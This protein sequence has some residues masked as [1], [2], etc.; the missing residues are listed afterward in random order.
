MDKLAALEMTIREEFPNFEV[1]RKSD[2]RLMSVIHTLLMCISF[3]QM[4]TFMVDFV[5][6]LGTTVYVPTKW[7]TWPVPSK[8][9]VLRHERVHMRQAKKYGR[10]LYSFLYLFVPLPIGL[11]YYRMLFEK[12]AYTESLRAYA[13]YYGVD[14]LRGGASRNSMVRHFTTAEYMWMW[15]FKKRMEK[16][17]DNEVSK[18]G[19]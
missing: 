13:D 4:R 10:V 8:M 2:S 12:E 11:A 7:E 6:T 17:Y 1:V 14:S 9:A 5:T 16:W 18:L 15:P 3:G 19:A